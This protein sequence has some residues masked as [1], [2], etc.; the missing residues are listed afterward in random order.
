[1]ATEDE[2]R[3]QLKRMCD[4][5][6]R[7]ARRAA[8]LDDYYE[9]NHRVPEA[10]SASKQTRAYLRL[11]ELSDTNWPQLIVD[12]VEERLEVQ[13]LSMGSE[14]A[15][16]RAWEIW[17]ANALD[18]DSGL[19]HQAALTAARAFVI[20]W[21]SSEPGG[22]PSVTIEHASTCLVEYAPGSR[23]VRVGAIRRW[24]DGA[25]WYAT[26]Y[27]PDGVYKFQTDPATTDPSSSP[28]ADQWVRREVQ[29]EDWP[30]S[31]PFDGR[32]NVIEL[33]VNRRLRPS[34]FGVAF[35]EFETNLG[36]I[37]RINYA[38]FSQIV[39]MTWSGFPL[40]A[41]IGD[42]V[43]RDDDGNPIKP[44][45]VS[46]DQVVLIENPEGKLIQLP[47][48]SL[49]NYG[50]AIDRYV[51]QL[52]A[53]TKTPAHYLL[54]KMVNVSA[55][56][57]RAAEAGLVS[58]VRRHHR[59]LGEAWEEV[60]RLALIA[61]GSAQDADLSSAEVIWKDPESR[62]LAERAD[63]ASKLAPILPWQALA[64]KVLQASPQEIAQWEGQRASDALTGLLNAPAP[65]QTNGSQMPGL[66]G[67]Q[68]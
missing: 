41:K 40:R 58:K 11:L 12:S 20:V 59:A 63:A 32:V 28:P 49:E 14:D 4:E 45:D 17:Q 1:M 24:T 7:R 42:P 21:P 27:R 60:A 31:N 5:L 44:F 62:S 65:A 66:P 15:S 47:E 8:L 36:H 61:D 23:R 39:A 57:I 50:M 34:P 19:A 29:G 43:T 10:V 53:L 48:A 35:G 68:R 56:A 18:A 22:A 64:S 26:L 37:D 9:G 2:L 46:A 16:D 67:M 3:G 30:L 38:L 13:G 54:G 33:A 6:D 55:D 52:A 51:E 25:R